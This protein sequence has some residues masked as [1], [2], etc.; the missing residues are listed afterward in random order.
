MGF[1]E[2]YERTLNEVKKC[3]L[4]CGRNPQDVQVLAVS[5]TVGELEIAEAIAAGA[6]NF[7][8]NRP[9]SLK[10]KH[11]AFPNQNWHFIGNIQSRRIPDIVACSS[12]VH[13]LYQES[14]V[15]K[16]SSAAIAAGK[17]QDV[18]L[19]VNISGEESKSGLA[20]DEVASMIALCERYPGIRVRGLMTMAPQGDPTVAQLCFENLLHLRDNLREDMNAS[21]AA[22]FNELS[23]GM[24]EDWREAVRAGSTIVRIGRALF[25]PRFE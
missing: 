12:L 10:T 6:G 1:K 21:A 3:C 17:V 23:M 5:K 18:L 22:V 15:A 9:D 14:H 13:S 20:P 11:S 16:F 7:G 24:S 25:D 4:E 8:E 19:E 2:R